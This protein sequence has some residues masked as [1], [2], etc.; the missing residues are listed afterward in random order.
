M[1]RTRQRE[2]RKFQ[3]SGIDARVVD[4]FQKKLADINLITGKAE[5]KKPKFITR[6]VAGWMQT[7][8]RD[9]IPADLIRLWWEEGEVA[10]NGGTKHEG[11]K[12]KTEVRKALKGSSR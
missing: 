12:L 4:D 6:I 2:K 3:I 7:V 11:K 5:E 9:C 8:G 10:K 1:A